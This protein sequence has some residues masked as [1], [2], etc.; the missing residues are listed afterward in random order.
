MYCTKSK[1]LSYGQRPLVKSCEIQ[2]IDET[3]VNN[4]L[5]CFIIRFY[6]KNDFVKIYID[7]KEDFYDYFF[8]K[9]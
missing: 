9:K 2:S 4:S 5:T 6:E 1:S 3:Y 8:E 7:K